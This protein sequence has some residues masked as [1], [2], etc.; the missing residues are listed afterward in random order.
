MDMCYNCV[1]LC[2]SPAYGCKMAPV[3]EILL[4]YL[5]NYPDVMMPSYNVNRAVALYFISF[6]VLSFFYLMN[7]V[8]AIAMDAYD[9]SIDERKCSRQELADRLLGEAFSL[10]DLDGD[11]LIPR[12][13]IM[14]V[15]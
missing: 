6:M 4:L 10:L 12:E 5:R 2:T 15:M 8:L 1:S 11:G 9:K 3:T 7:L 13:S 14:H